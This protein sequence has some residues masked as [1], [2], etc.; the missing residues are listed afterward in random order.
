MQK[1]C[2]VDGRRF[3]RYSLWGNGVLSA[4]YMDLCTFVLIVLFCGDFDTTEGK[5]T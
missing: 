3:R 4:V 5:V 1:T 2:H